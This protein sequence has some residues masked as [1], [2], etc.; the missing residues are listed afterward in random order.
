MLAIA[1]FQELRTGEVRRISL[2]RC[3]VNK[4]RT[5]PNSLRIHRQFTENSSPTAK[6]ACRKGERGGRLEMSLKSTSSV[7]R[8]PVCEAGRDLIKNSSCRHRGEQDLKRFVT[9][10]VAACMALTLS[11]AV[12]SADEVSSE[13]HAWNGYHWARSANPFTV[14]LGDNVSADWDSYLNVAARDWNQ[15]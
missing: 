2:P 15:S 6:R 13:S 10:L 3:S 5:R 11:A 9:I 14:N 1:N 4:L 12:A 7:N 8:E